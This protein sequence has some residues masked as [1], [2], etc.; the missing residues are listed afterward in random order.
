MM[1]IQQN[2]ELH[3]KHDGHSTNLSIFDGCKNMGF[4]HGSNYT[5]IRI[6][7]II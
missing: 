6:E 1:V 4:S 5:T 7:G 3:L 2:K